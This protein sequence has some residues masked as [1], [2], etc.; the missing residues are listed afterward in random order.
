MN[1]AL[2]ENPILRGAVSRRPGGPFTSS[3]D[4]AVS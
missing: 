4:G 1:D 3:F 2:T